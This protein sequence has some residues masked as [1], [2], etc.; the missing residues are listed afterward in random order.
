MNIYFW[1]YPYCFLLKTENGETIGYT[2][3]A[4]KRWGY[5]IYPHPIS[6]FDV[7]NRESLWMLALE[8]LVEQLDF[9]HILVDVTARSDFLA[10][11]N[12]FGGEVNSC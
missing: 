11:C 8:V 10:D 9:T 6:S 4:K 5:E 7:S 2:G 1:F 12:R 3:K